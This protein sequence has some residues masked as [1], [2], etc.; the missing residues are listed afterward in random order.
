MN[1][2]T[3]LERLL[4]HAEISTGFLYSSRAWMVPADANVNGHF[5]SASNIE[6]K[7]NCRRAQLFSYVTLLCS[8]RDCADEVS[9]RLCPMSIAN[10]QLQ[11]S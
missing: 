5:F 2:F 3:K 9:D 7:E 1:F 10:C 4:M 8:G 6:M 11:L